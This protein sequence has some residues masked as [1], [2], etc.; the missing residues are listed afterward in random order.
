M[1]L[2]SGKGLP[3]QKT[4]TG[5]GPVRFSLCATLGTLSV[6]IQNYIPLIHAIINA[7]LFLE[8]A[9]D[10]EIDPDS[11]VRCMEHMAASL[12]TLDERIN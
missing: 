2:F 1:A 6:A 9:G 4:L 7:L 10:D 8:S 5:P 3:R 11:A 12:L